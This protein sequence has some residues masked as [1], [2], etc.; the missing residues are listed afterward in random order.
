MNCAAATIFTAVF[1]L[2][3]LGPEIDALSLYKLFIAGGDV[4]SFDVEVPLVV[5]VFVGLHP[6]R[7]YLVG[8]C[9]LERLVLVEVRRGGHMARDDLQ[10]WIREV[11]LFSK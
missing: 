5:H 2:H 4:I 3:P 9:E 7:L 10:A 1:E 6:E 11:V 8:E